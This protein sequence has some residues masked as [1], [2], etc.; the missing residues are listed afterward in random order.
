MKHAVVEISGKQ[1]LVSEGSKVKVA[2]MNA[3]EGKQVSL[4]EV[5]LSSGPKATNLGTPY[6]KD[7][8]V[9]AV[10]SRHARYPRVAGVKMK[11]KKRRQKYF[12]HRQDYTELTINK[13]TSK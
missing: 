6:L 7:V 1:Y 12:T 13:I 5:L 10:I 3:E 2:K 11:A 9:E 4:T 8:K